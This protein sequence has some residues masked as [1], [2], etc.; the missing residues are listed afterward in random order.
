M[1]QMV[2]TQTPAAWLVAAL[3]EDVFQNHSNNG[4][5][6]LYPGIKQ[7]PSPRQ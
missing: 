3:L 7:T 5:R 4:L 6:A 2:E 1:S